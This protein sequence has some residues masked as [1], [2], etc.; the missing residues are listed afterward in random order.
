[1]R[2]SPE[3]GEA[4]SYFHSDHLGSSNVITDQNGNKVSHYEY[5]PYGSTSVQDV[6]G[7]EPVNYLF[8]GKELD[9]TGLYFYGARYYDPEIGRFI[10]SDIDY[11]GTI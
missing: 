9:S 1:L 7:T 11:P 8:N 2:A 4:I 5:T 3:A 6:N 10:T